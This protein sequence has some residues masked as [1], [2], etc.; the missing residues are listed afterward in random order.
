MATSLNRSDLLNYTLKQVYNFFP[1]SKN[2]NKKDIISSFNTNMERIEYCFSKIRNKYFF[3]NNDVLFKHLHGDQ[4]S[5]FLYI[6]SNTLYKNNYDLTLCEKLFL[7]NKSLFSLDAFYE[8]ELPE[9]FL[10]VHPLGTVLGRA[11]YSNYLIVYQRCNIGS[12]HDIYPELGEHLT[13]HPGASILGKCHIGR[14]VK[15]A[16]DG[17]VIDKN[18]ENDIVYIGN[19]KNYIKKSLTDIDSIWLI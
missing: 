7:L 19:P 1:D 4:Y 18:I 15:I 3:Q 9:I 6:L 8:I 17:L 13:L 11:K 16:T 10:F 12:N 5:M 14:N 2:Y